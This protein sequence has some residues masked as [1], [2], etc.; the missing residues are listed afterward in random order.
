MRKGKVIHVFAMKA[1][2]GRVCMVP[3]IINLA[4]QTGVIGESHVSLALPTERSPSNHSVGVGVGCWA[5][6]DALEGK[7]FLAFAGKLNMINGEK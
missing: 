4:A 1:Y 2:G 5:S 7:N 3:R 6:L